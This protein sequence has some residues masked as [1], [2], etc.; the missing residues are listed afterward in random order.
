MNWI[1]VNSA[2]NG[3]NDTPHDMKDNI[4]LRSVNHARADAA[5]IK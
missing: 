5:I 3:A 2:I 1:P 4:L